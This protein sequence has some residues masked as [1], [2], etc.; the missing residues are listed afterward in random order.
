MINGLV[1]FKNLRPF[2]F[3]MIGPFI[4]GVIDNGGLFLGMSFIEDK[5]IAMGFDSIVAAGFGNTFSDAIGAVCGGGVTIFLW[6]KFGIPKDV[7]FW[8]NLIGIILGCLLPV[9][10]KMAWTIFS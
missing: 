6:K 3:G 7:S 10:I 8:P 4:F 2:L 5:L 1:V 9:S